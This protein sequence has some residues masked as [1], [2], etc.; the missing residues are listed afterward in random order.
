M[1]TDIRIPIET[2]DGQTVFVTPGQLMDGL[3]SLIQ[4][5]EYARS[6]HQQLGVLVNPTPMLEEIAALASSK[7]ES[8]LAYQ[9]V[10]TFLKKGGLK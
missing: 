10:E 6:V 1:S 7:P 4:T 2:E 5:V 3:D 9:V 8:S